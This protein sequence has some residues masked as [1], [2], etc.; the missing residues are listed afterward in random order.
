MAGSAI[1]TCK[2]RP[3]CWGFNLSVNV[4]HF[5]TSFS[6]VTAIM[7]QASGSISSSHNISMS[8]INSQ[9]SSTL[10]KQYA[11]LSSAQVTDSPSVADFSDMRPGRVFLNAWSLHGGH[12]TLV[13]AM[14]L[15]SAISPFGLHNLVC[16]YPHGKPIWVQMIR[17]PDPLPFAAETSPASAI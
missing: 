15:P 2:P 8:I 11:I 5:P 9:D 16:H 13:D 4:F 3:K 14:R 12:G 10:I 7:L 6:E 17:D 1:I